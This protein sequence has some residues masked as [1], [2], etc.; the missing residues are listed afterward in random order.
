MSC[1]YS[2]DSFQLA[3]YISDK[4]LNWQVSWA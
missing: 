2:P 3:S 1:A 4:A